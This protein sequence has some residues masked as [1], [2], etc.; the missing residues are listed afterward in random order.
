MKQI[1][2]KSRKAIAQEVP[3]PIITDKNHILVKNLYSLVYQEKRSVKLENSTRSVLNKIEVKPSITNLV[4]NDF[5]KNGIHGIVYKTIDKLNLLL[6]QEVGYSTSGMVIGTGS[7]VRDIKIGDLVS[8]V[9]KNFAKHAEIICLPDNFVTKI[10]DGVDTIDAST[11]AIGALCIQSIKKMNLKKGD[12]VYLTGSGSPELI[13]SQILNSRGCKVIR[14]DNSRKKKELAK[15]ISIDISSSS[16]D[17]KKLEK[18]IDLS[19]IKEFSTEYIEKEDVREYLKLIADKKVDLNQ[20]KSKI[21]NIDSVGAAFKESKRENPKMTF[22]EYTGQVDE[23]KTT[24]ILDKK[25]TKNK[26]KIGVIGAG[27]IS[28]EE[29]LPHIKKNKRLELHMIVDRNPVNAQK[30]AKYFKAKKSSTSYKDAI[31][32]PQIDTV[33]IATKN[34]S[35]AEIIME[36]AKQKKPIFVEKPLAMNR[37]A[38]KKIE[39]SVKK[40]NVPIMVCFNR[41]FSKYSEEVL[42][43]TEKR[44]NPLMINYRVNAGYRPPSDWTQNLKIGGGRIIGEA[45]HMIDL[46][47]YFTK[48]KPK[49][50]SVSSITPKDKNYTNVDNSIITI[51]YQDGSIC[52]LFYTSLG[53]YKMPK[54]YIEI[55][56]DQEVIVINDFKEIKIMGKNGKI[57]T[58]KGFDKGLKKILNEWVSYLSNKNK[59]IPIKLE[60]SILSTKMTFDIM[61][62]IPNN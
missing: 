12:T 29:H 4:I 42:K 17:S 2:I 54:E 27:Y 52:N 28:K 34:N 41:R 24:I 43:K 36:S 62:L 51:E 35:H 9:G 13:I 56:C 61:D 60:D 22:I 50:I 31:N 19:K 3:A 7:N 40:Y 11:A 49:K 55:Y 37:E 20:L 38:F 16:K 39:E 59:D 32:D 26:I 1:L 58:K 6:G 48:S 30:T 33:L 8:C 23:K 15:Q 47:N 21:Y 14:I 45:C 18:C 25:T 44:K 5:K 57:K 46:F 53:N 10:P